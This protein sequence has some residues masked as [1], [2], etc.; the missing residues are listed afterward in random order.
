VANGN[1]ENKWLLRTL[2]GFMFI[3][4][5]SMSGILWSVLS[6]ADE[7]NQEDIKTVYS[8]VKSDIEAVEAHIEN[9]VETKESHN[10]DIEHIKEKFEAI[11][12]QNAAIRNLLLEIRREVKN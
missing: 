5:T 1:S 8:E 11:S 2:F 7:K 6:E 9:K 12:K 3:V 4:M 10:K